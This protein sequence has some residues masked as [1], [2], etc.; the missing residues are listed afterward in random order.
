MI[1]RIVIRLLATVLLL[2]AS[3]VAA[4]QPKKCPG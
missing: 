3:P 4:Q 2:A 1:K